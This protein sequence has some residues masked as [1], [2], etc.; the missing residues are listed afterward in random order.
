VNRKS[1]KL[2]LGIGVALFVIGSGPLLVTILLANL[3]LT[4]D[5]NPNPIGFGLLA[6]LT[7][8]PSILLMVI[9]GW[10]LRKAP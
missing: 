3:G 8:W 4:R 7:F 10:Q 6:F 2:V 9:G 5:P 1:A